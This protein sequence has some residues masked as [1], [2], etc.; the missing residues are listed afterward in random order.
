MER[1]D[2]RSSS[3]VQSF[4]KRGGKSGL[5]V[6]EFLINGNPQRLK[7]ARGGVRFMTLPAGAGKRFGHRVD[8]FSR[9]PHGLA[10][11]AGDNRARN[12][13]AGRLFAVAKEEVR[14]LGFLEC[15]EELRGGLPLCRVETHVERAACLKPKAAVRIGQL[16]RGEPQVEQNAVDP[17]DSELIQDLWQLRITGLP[18]DAARVGK[19]LGRP[20]EHQGIAI[21]SDEFSGGTE[22]FEE[23]ATMASGSDRPVNDDQPWLDV[24]KLDDF[25]YEDGPMNGRALVSRGPRRI[26]HC[27]EW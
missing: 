14:Q 4:G 27:D 17:R 16:I 25:P 11:A 23:D 7:D 5:E 22:V 13:S 8:Q 3:G 26:R 6:I 24:E 10:G 2:D 19:T 21:K 15:G 18:Q 12:R 20:G 1:D 9:C